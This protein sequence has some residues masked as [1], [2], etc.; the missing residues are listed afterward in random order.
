M[1]NPDAIGYR[2]AEGNFRGFYVHWSPDIEDLSKVLVGLGSVDA[3]KAWIE[4]AI[5]AGGYSYCGSEG[6]SDM[7]DDHEPLVITGKDPKSEAYV[8]GYWI[9][10]DSEWT[11][12]GFKDAKD[13]YVADGGDEEEFGDEIWG[14]THETEELIPVGV[15]LHYYTV[16]RF[17]EEVARFARIAAQKAAGS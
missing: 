17:A 6:G 13:E 3:I 7:Y 14:D 9:I 1:S 4:E 11:V 12:K 16:A 15:I 2:D 10:Q 8:N 5:E